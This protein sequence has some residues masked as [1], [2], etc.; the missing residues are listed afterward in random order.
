L[1][2]SASPQCRLTPIF[3]KQERGMTFLAV[4]P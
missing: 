1:P 3:S 2:T 4:M